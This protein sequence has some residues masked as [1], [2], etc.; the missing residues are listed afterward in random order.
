MKYELPRDNLGYF[1]ELARRV[2]YR[3]LLVF[4]GKPIPGM[5]HMTAEQLNY[6]LTTLLKER[7]I[8][9]DPTN[10]SFF[11]SPSYTKMIPKVETSLDKALQVISSFVPQEISE[12]FFIRYPV[13]I[14]FITA[15]EVVTQF[16]KP[17]T[18][19]D[20]ATVSS[21][22]FDGDVLG[23]AT[24]FRTS[25]PSQDLQDKVVHIAALCGLSAEQTANL[26][27]YGMFH[28]SAVMPETNDKFPVFQLW[29]EP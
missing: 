4:F 13:H 26:Q 5:E 28:Y 18:A 21:T 6:H 10:D 11:V 15:D 7:K 12:I 9:R 17:N 8:K 23:A 29:R 2:S 25:L 24:F 27:S 16:L 22:Y 20:I 14:M 3:N 19:Y 1:I